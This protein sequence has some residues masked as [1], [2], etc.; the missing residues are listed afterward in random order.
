M[1]QSWI[2]P[3][4]SSRYQTQCPEP[5]Q[6]ISNF[7]T[8]GIIKTS[9]ANEYIWG[10]QSWNLSNLRAKATRHKSVLIKPQDKR[11]VC[12]R[13]PGN[14]RRTI[15]GL[16]KDKMQHIV[17]E[18][19]L[20]PMKCSTQAQVKC[21]E[22]MTVMELTNAVSWS[23]AWVE[24]SKHTE[25]WQPQR[26]F[27]LP[28]SYPI[29]HSSLHHLWVSSP[30]RTRRAPLRVARQ[31]HRAFGSQ[32]LTANWKMNQND[33]SRSN[34]TNNFGPVSRFGFGQAPGGETKK[35]EKKKSSV[36]FYIYIQESST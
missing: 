29:S 20:D 21:T 31:I 15:E 7:Q 34:M 13:L 14:H 18:H 36:C 10:L 32:T 1:G 28:H 23:T 19:E 24:H 27:P 33:M 9:A 5:F 17:L 26:G 4:D 22:R 12:K 8:S 35:K 16:L 25:R 11:L 6:C 2:N 3:R 30:S